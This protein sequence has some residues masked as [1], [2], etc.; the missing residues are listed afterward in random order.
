MSDGELWASLSRLVGEAGRT[1][2]AAAERAADLAAEQLSPGKD[3]W[4]W[5]LGKLIDGPIIP[6]PYT[7]TGRKLS[8]QDGYLASCERRRRRAACL[9]NMA[10]LHAATRA[11]ADCHQR[12]V[13]FIAAGALSVSRAVQHHGVQPA[14]AGLVAAQAALHCRPGGYR[15]LQVRLARQLLAA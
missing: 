9:L 6:E 12:P 14:T 3:Q 4:R 8:W 1:A 5:P 2:R 15:L 13:A 7:L 10:A 11:L